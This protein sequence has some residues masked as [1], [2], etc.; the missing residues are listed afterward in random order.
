MSDVIWGVTYHKS[1]K[2]TQH[3]LISG[4][5][6]GVSYRYFT[7]TCA[8]ELKLT[9][10]VRNLSDGRVESV[11]Q[12]GEADLTELYNRLKRGPRAAEVSFIEVQVV[13][14]HENMKEFVIAEDGDRPWQKK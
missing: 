8:L 14:A 12:G 4:H 10:W 2:T 5:V 3:L 7:K 6:Q 1:M 11:V 13:E 9:G